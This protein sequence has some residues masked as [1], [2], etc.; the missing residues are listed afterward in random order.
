MKQLDL[1]RCTQLALIMGTEAERSKA[2]YEKLKINLDFLAFAD[3]LCW[4][5]YNFAIACC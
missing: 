1:P 4:K 2:L 3:V 5:H